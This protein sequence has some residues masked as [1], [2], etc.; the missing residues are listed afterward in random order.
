MSDKIAVV[1]GGLEPTA[2]IAQHV[3]HAQHV[4]THVEA[5]AG[6]TIAQL[7][8]AHGQE[9]VRNAIIAALATINVAYAP[10]RRMSGEMI[11]M[12]AE[13]LAERNPHES[14]ADIRLF[15]RHCATSGFEAGNTYGALDM[16]LLMRWWQMHT[17]RKAEAIEA[18]RKE[19]SK[20]KRLE[21][22][23]AIREHP[24]LSG[25]LAKA[26]AKV[27]ADR[28]AEG[29]RDHIAEL[30]LLKE[31]LPTMDRDEMRVAWLTAKR[32]HDILGMAAIEHDAERRGFRGEEA[33]A[34]RLAVDEAE[35][36]SCAKR[37]GENGQYPSGM[38]AAETFTNDEPARYGHQ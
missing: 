5:F 29:K 11:V 38:D 36:A 22:E 17:D 32:E 18:M 24:T 14:L 37:V 25:E 15:A 19:E 1:H 7:T 28:E 31:A 6:A 13:A 35:R 21:L 8:K 4:R 30:R 2:P 20:T 33:R 23:T 3:Q 9:Q 12:L 16:P 27:K 34:A 26:A 10:A